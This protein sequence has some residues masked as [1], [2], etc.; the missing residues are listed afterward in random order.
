[1]NDTSNLDPQ[2]AAEAHA[3][4]VAEA[5]AAEATEIHSAEPVPASLTLAPNAGPLEKIAQAVGRQITPQQARVMEVTDAL[6]P[7]YLKAS[8]LELTL[9]EIR[10]LQ[11]VFPDSAVEIRP[12]DGL[13]WIP[14]I[15][16][17]NRL[18]RVFHPG[19]W[20]TICR[21]HWIDR[22]TIVPKTKGEPPYDITTMY[23]E[24]VLVVR[25]CF[26]GESIGGHP[27][28]PTNPKTNFSDAL[29]S[30][31][32][33]ALR[34]I[35]G[36]T[37]G[38]GS[39]V[40]DPS[41]SRDWVQQYAFQQ[42]G[43]WHK[44]VS[45]QGTSHPPVAPRQSSAPPSASKQAA[46]G[47]S[48]VQQAPAPA[49]GQS[50]AGNPC[51]KCR[52][53]ATKKSADYEGVQFCQRCGWQ[54]L[55]KTGQYYEEH[56]FMRVICTMPPKGVPMAEYKEHP[57]TLGQIARI[58]NKRWYG[59]VM[60]NTEAKQAEGYTSP[61]SGKH[62]PATNAQLAFG[63]ACEE[64][65]HYLEEQRQ[66]KEEGGRGAATRKESNNPDPDEPHD[67]DDVPF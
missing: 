13:I 53:T 4:M 11:E 56:D 6:A 7:A 66:L 26:V 39:Q 34:R 35:C 12:N 10:A 49:R 52:A 65:V 51:P 16:I 1:M 44:R 37:L 63:R 59:L 27:Y 31:R 36:K 20:A 55:L 61:N 46:A 67:D 28:Q 9:E 18:N 62:Y 5:E 21:R 19:K 33:E 48:A 45:P 3:Q 58:D 41:Y 54:W 17:S 43:K 14:H 25:G 47:Q 30:T 42:H 32:A 64:A 60:N 29:E 24:Y 40:W 57:Q 2:A 38:C 50:G 22:Q 15:H 8:T 23:G